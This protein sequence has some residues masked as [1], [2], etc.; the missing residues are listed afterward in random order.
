MLHS[1]LSNRKNEEKKR[2]KKKKARYIATK[3]P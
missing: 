1:E 2:R 3:N